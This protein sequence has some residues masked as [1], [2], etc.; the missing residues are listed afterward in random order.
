MNNEFFTILL[1]YIIVGFFS[2]IITFA[3]LMI[4]SLLGH[5][6]IKFLNKER[7]NENE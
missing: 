5:K 6:F 2:V 7:K 1:F 4:C 3:P